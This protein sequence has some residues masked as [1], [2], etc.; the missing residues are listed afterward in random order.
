MFIV[1]MMQ[2]NE[3]GATVTVL[4]TMIKAGEGVGLVFQRLQKITR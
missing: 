2:S 4:H 1:A 3:E